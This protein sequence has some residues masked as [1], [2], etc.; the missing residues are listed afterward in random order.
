VEKKKKNPKQ[1]KKNILAN[2]YF[3]EDL[4]KED[5]RLWLILKFQKCLIKEF[6]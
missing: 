2:P 3:P 5:E 1:Q 6:I 4:T